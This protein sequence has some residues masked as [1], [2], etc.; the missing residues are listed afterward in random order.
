MLPR[1]RLLTIN[2]QL[3]T[4]HY[5]VT[6]LEKA[7]RDGSQFAAKLKGTEKSNAQIFLLHLLAAIGH[8]SNTLPEG[9]TFDYRVRLAD[10]AVLP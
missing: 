8:D 2:Y 1:R 3:S 6:S 7:L 9:S 4:I 5:Q 10:P